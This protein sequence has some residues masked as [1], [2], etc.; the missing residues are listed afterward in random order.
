MT[1]SHRFYVFIL[2]ALVILPV[3]YVGYTGYTYY[4]TPLQE[5][6]YHENHQVLKPGGSW[7]HGLGIAGSFAMLVGVASYM[8]RKRSRT[9]ARFG[10]LKHWL[11]FHIFLCTLGP[12]LVLFHTSFKFG[13]IVAVSFWSMVA[14]FLSGIIG[15][16][17]YL[18]IPRSIEGRELSL[19]EI[20][21]L[22]LNVIRQIT[23]DSLKSKFFNDLLQDPSGPASSPE[24][25]DARKGTNDRQRIDKQT[26]RRI[27]TSMVAAGYSGREIKKLLRL[28]KME[29]RLDRR[30]KRLVTMQQLFRYWHVAHLPFA[31]VMLIIMVIHVVVTILFGYRWIF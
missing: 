2:G 3:A 16:F 30:I 19:Q 25:T 10:K 5:R 20:E 15:R 28:V 6:F 4:T 11:E 23:E 12:A 14:V 18:Q 26:L 13:G 21:E 24:S 8:I 9:L 29:Q 27:R 1:A 17:I 22:R 7:G 31:M